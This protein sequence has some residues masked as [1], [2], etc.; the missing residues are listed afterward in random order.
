MLV[1]K[2]KPPEVTTEKT[3]FDVVYQ[4]KTFHWW[5]SNQYGMDN[6]AEIKVN[7]HEKKDEIGVGF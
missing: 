3:N 7:E 4:L 2:P 1:Q 6:S 5:P